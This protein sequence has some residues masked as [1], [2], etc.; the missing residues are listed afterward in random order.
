MVIDGFPVMDNPSSGASTNP[1][2]NALER[3]NPKDIES[4]TFLKD[5]AAA[6]IWGARS[7]NGVIVITTKKGQKDG[8]W[9]VEGS[10]QLT[11]AKKQNV[12]Q[13][14]NLASASQTINYEKWLFEKSM[15]SSPYSRNITNLYSGLTKSQL[16]LYQGYNWGTMDMAEMNRQLADLASLDN[17]KQIRDNLLQRP[18]QSMT[19]VALSGGIGQWGTRFSVEFIH[20]K[21]IF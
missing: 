6:S 2:L 7:A 18:L 19:N 20:E 17:T 14:T 13:L 16:L 4:I 5:A 10:T 8:Q 12:H 3:I 9:T 11:I 1:N 21:G 15:I